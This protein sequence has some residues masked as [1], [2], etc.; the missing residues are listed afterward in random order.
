M[1][2][3]N[4]NSEERTGRLAG[5]GQM[6]P[7]AL[8]ALMRTEPL[9][10]AERAAISEESHDHATPIGRLRY[11]CSVLLA[12]GRGRRARIA[13]LESAC[14][15]YRTAWRG[16]RTR[17][18]STGG[19]ADRYAARARDL[20]AA[21]QDLLIDAISAQIERD[22]GRRRVIELSLR[23]QR[24]RKALA[25]A[26]SP[27]RTGG[28]PPQREAKIR[29]SLPDD[30]FGPPWTAEYVEGDGKN[31]AHYQVKA[32][33]GGVIA[34]LPD[35]LQDLALFIADA[36]E[37]ISELLAELDRVRT[38]ACT[39]VGAPIPARPALLPE[40]YAC[41]RCDIARRPHDRQ[42]TEVGGHTWVRPS[43]EQVLAR[44]KARSAARKGAA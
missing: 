3:T 24:V 1:K 18:L 30:W 31:R 9:T 21:A 23:L 42:Y 35:W 8:V 12:D 16:A 43:N 13:E 4:A 28:L 38:V 11:L 37:A 17:A 5:P 2:D 15:R 32:R 10:A 27:L 34:T 26:T 40:P 19:A 25:V 7:E 14:A 33:N 41:A 39:G 20:Q 29:A 6:P 22:S 36:P 44:M